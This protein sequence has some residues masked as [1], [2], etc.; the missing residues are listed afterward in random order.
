[1]WE[2]WT[3]LVA[4]FRRDGTIPKYNTFKTDYIQLYK[5]IS[6]GVYDSVQLTK[7]SIRKQSYQ[8]IKDYVKIKNKM[9]QAV[10]I[11]TVWPHFT[12]LFQQSDCCLKM[13]QISAGRS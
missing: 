3:N 2:S 6:L 1:M 9:R 8:N 10:D 13:S 4:P 11:E 5:T 12:S 7:W